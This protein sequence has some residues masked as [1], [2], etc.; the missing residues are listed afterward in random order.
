MR[1]AE[2]RVAVVESMESTAGTVRSVYGRFS[3]PSSYVKVGLGVGAGLLGMWLM[4]RVFSAGSRRVAT[5]LSTPAA[6]ARTT[7]GALILLLV[8]VASALILPWVRERLHGADLGHVLKRM[9]PSHILFR[10]L[11]LEK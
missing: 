6:P 7:S 1:V 2:S 10:W 11:G 9:Q 8:Q 3:V 4:K 5:A